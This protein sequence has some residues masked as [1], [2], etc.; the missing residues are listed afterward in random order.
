M[1][2]IAR[3][4]LSLWKGEL[5][6]RLSM[7]EIAAAV[8]DQHRVSVAE[9]RGRGR[10]ARLVAARQRF[11]AEAYAQGRWSQPTIGRWLDGRD[12]STIHHGIAAHRGRAAR[13]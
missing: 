7:A 12:H 1:A 13:P 4:V 8:A 10:N 2:P 6:A 5:P 11:M 9:I 3:T